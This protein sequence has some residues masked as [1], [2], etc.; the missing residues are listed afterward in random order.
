MAEK[1][2]VWDAVDENGEL[3]GFDLYR[4]EWDIKPVPEGAH[5]RMAEIFT[6][7][8]QG[9][10]LCTQR[11]PKK[12]IFALKWEVTGG[13]VVK[14]EK[15]LAGAVREL[16]E[17]TGIVKQPEELTFLLKLTHDSTVFY[18]YAA[19]VENADIPITLQEGETID[20]KFLPYDEFCDFIQSET[21][22]DSIRERFPAYQNAIE[23]YVK[24]VL[25]D[26]TCKK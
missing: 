1:R 6:V 15:P 12:Q 5:H 25:K 20:Y 7:T 10:I 26:V 18:V 23:T 14:G 13:S 17:E 24:Q 21:F 11:D 8:R 2:E 22:D 9:E 19:T 4:D 3:L 16:R